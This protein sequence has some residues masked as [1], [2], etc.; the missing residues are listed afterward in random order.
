L[1]TEETIEAAK[2]A[3]RIKGVVKGQELARALAWL[4]P[5][6]LIW[7][8]RVNNYLI[9][10]DPAT[11]DVLYWNNDP[12]RRSAQLH[13]EMLD[14]F[15]TNAFTHPGMLKVLGTAI[16]LSKVTN[17]AYVIAGLT[18][19]ITP[20]QAYYASTQLLGGTCKF[21]MS[22]SGHI[23]A[24]LNPP[25]NAKANYFVNARCPADPEQWLAG[26]QPRSGSWWEDYQAWLGKRAGEQKPAPQELG[27]N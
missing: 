14:L 24:I 10:N 22:N 20:W 8:Y 4:R 21:I 23:L 25:G 17:D 12:T 9:G 13:G 3:S 11:F 1:T 6:D 19:H 2:Q 27:N 15:E 7:N 5:N 16:D 18:D 26:V